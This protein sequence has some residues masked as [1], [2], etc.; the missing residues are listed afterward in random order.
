MATKKKDT[1]KRAQ[2]EIEIPYGISRKVKANGEVVYIAS[3][4][5]G[6]RRRQYRFDSLEDAAAYRE[7]YFTVDAELVEAGRPSLTRESFLRSRNGVAQS[8]TAAT[9]NA[10]IRAPVR[11]VAMLNQLADVR[12]ASAKATNMGNGA[13]QL[14][15]R[16][17]F[18]LE[19]SP[20]MVIARANEFT[21]DFADKTARKKCRTID[22]DDDLD[23]ADRKDVARYYRA[24]VT[25]INERASGCKLLAHG[26]EVIHA[27]QLPI[28]LH[29]QNYT[30]AV[31]ADCLKL[32]QLLWDMAIARH[33]VAVNVFSGLGISRASLPR[34]SR[35]GEDR[36]LRE[37]AAW[38]VEQLATI[39]RFLRPQYLLPYWM[40]VILGFRKSE[41]FGF[42]IDDW[43]ASQ[44]QLWLAKQRR[45]S[46][47][48]G[49]T[50]LKRTDSKRPIPV[51]PALAR[52]IDNYID[53]VHGQPPTDPIALKKWRNRYL[54]VGVHG[55]PMDPNSCASAVREAERS[56]GL[57]IEDVGAHRPLHHLRKT[58]SAALQATP[59]IS[60]RA[61]S[62]LLGHKIDA[63]DQ[64]KRA[65]R[66][67]EQYYSPVIL[68]EL[69]KL[70]DVVDAWVTEE[71]LPAFGSD[72]L[73][74]SPNFTD[75]VS[76][77]R[78]AELLSLSGEVVTKE[79][80]ITLIASGRLDA[81]RINFANGGDFRLASISKPSV[82]A[83]TRERIRERAT[84]YSAGEVCELLGVTHGV[85]YRL[86]ERGSFSQIEGGPFAKPHL[87][88]GGWAPGGGRRFPKA[89][90]DAFV[91]ANE[92]WLLRRREWLTGIEVK[93][94]FGFDERRLRKLG[95]AG[96]I[97]IWRDPH[98]VHHNRYYNPDSVRSWVNRNKEISIIEAAT[99]L[100]VKVSEV[101]ALIKMG[102][103]R[104]GSK[105]TQLLESSVFDYR[106]SLGKT[107]Q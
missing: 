102:V 76:P 87:T 49:T 3:A 9:T 35:L 62:V 91:A 53:Q 88:G 26:I 20:N 50:P 107:M 61:V 96:E 43:D 27:E 6:P 7:M 68:G 33:Y 39:A 104:S 22:L 19:A 58:L 85:V 90:V 55:G 82:D 71:L 83:L 69:K 4:G 8:V 95:D 101:R 63:V 67:T 24:Q 93:A 2:L 75:V 74:T 80:V 52:A 46:P 81:T 37:A 99:T 86:A 28:W 65:A 32:A 13:F 44:T 41:A 94:I 10:A 64:S 56:A 84:S 11:V 97:Q 59:G 34:Y 18:D 77:S 1:T 89:E 48:K 57:L 23:E 47:V 73:L 25:G 100:G 92:L 98:L 14:L 40:Y 42:R 105:P 16:F 17:F 51:P 36:E 103:L 54:I 5:T 38:T 70:V 60:P 78:A 31:Q 66:T 30:P 45:A 79:N 15:K 29:A 72:D 21:I 106:D 12:A